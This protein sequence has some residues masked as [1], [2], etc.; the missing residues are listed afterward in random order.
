MMVGRPSREVIMTAMIGCDDDV[1]FVSAAKDFS[2]AQFAAFTAPYRSAIAKVESMVTL[3][4]DRLDDPRR[5]RP[6]EAVTSRVKSFDRIVDKAARIGCPLEPE[7]V[8]AAIRDIAGVRIVCGGVSDVYRLARHLGALPGLHVT[9]VEDYIASPKPN[10]YRS[11][12]VMGEVV[13]S[14]SRRIERVPIEIQLRTR[15]MDLW[16]GFDHRFVYRHHRSVPQRLAR[17]LAHAAELAHRLDVT[18]ER[19]RHDLAGTRTADP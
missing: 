10:G 1:D 14:V 16:A 4:G 2:R 17:E 18:L 5:G 12:H 13:V 15:A 3:L 9:E 6:V 11:F 7:A 8:G 19:L